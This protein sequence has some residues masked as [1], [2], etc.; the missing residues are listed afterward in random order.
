[1]TILLNKTNG[2]TRPILPAI[3]SKACYERL[4]GVLSENKLEIP[5][6]A[7]IIMTAVKTSRGV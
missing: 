6:Q 2:H 3:F 4:T 1:M 7:K 5:T